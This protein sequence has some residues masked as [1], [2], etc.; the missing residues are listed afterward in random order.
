MDTS[1]NLIRC[2]AC[3]QMV[4]N[5]KFCQEC[6]S[7][8]KSNRLNLDTVS[9]EFV[10]AFFNTTSRLAFTV[11]H[12]L[13][14][15]GE[16]ILAYVDGKRGKY[17]P[18]FS[19][20]ACSLVFYTLYKTYLMTFLYRLYVGT[21]VHNFNMTDDQIREELGIGLNLE[22]ITLVLLLLGMAVIGWVVCG[23]KWWEKG[24]RTFFLTES[25]VVFTYIYGTNFFLDPFIVSL[26][27]PFWRSIKDL[28][29]KDYIDVFTDI[30][31]ILLIG[32]M[33][34]AFCRKAKISLLRYIITFVVGFF[35]YY[36]M[37]NHFKTFLIRINNGVK[38]NL[39]E[40]S[41]IITGVFAGLKR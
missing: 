28:V 32:Y 17:Q 21:Q 3:E 36:F 34:Y 4:P 37:A 8:T 33:A 20:F 35:Y 2:Q 10:A 13:L 24:K 16:T 29:T 14:S 18:P 5:A 1:D 38:F 41:W 11:K 40:L 15:P 27:I 9:K 23:L 31:L 25:V 19:Y 30:P 26:E 6:G 7:A 39:H 22:N 12:L